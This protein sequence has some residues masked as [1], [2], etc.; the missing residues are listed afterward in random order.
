[1]F[2]YKN[3]YIYILYNPPFPYFEIWNYIYIHIYTYIHVNAYPWEHGCPYSWLRINIDWNIYSKMQC[4]T[5]L[6]YFNIVNFWSHKINQ[7]I[8]EISPHVTNCVCIHGQFDGSVLS[9]HACASLHH[10]REAHRVSQCSHNGRFMTHPRTLTNA[11]INSS[12]IVWLRC[13]QI[14]GNCFEIVH[15]TSLYNTNCRCIL[16]TNENIY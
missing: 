13:I 2:K 9:L 8:I 14:N 5:T 16:E 15:T 4:V 3:V 1:M 7:N 6:V 12:A 10:S 11:Q